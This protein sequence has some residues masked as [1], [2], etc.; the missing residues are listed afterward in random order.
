M[1]NGYSSSQKNMTVEQESDHQNNEIKVMLD[2]TNK[3]KLALSH[4]ASSVLHSFS[5][6]NKPGTRW[7]IFDSIDNEATEAIAASKIMNTFRPLSLFKKNSGHK[8]AGYSELRT[9]YLQER[10]EER[11]PD[12]NENTLS[13]FIKYRSKQ[14]KDFFSGNNCCNN[15]DLFRK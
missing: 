5:S 12:K 1:A 11:N 4:S 15:F 10:R 8:Y 14:L 7:D 6:N 13:M 2:T 9:Q 3:R